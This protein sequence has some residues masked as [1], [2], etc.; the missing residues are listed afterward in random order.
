MVAGGGAD[1]QPVDGAG[2]KVLDHHINML[3]QALHR[4][5]IPVHRGDAEFPSNRRVVV[6]VVQADESGGVC[7]VDGSEGQ[8]LGQPQRV[9]GAIT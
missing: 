9:K 6:P 8:H 1:A 5:P 3:H 2:G 7:E 4:K